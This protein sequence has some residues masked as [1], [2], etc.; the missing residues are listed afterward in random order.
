MKKTLLYICFILI[1]NYAFAVEVFILQKPA[2]KGSFLKINALKQ[3]NTKGQQITF[4]AA[5]GTD[6]FGWEVKAATNSTQYLLVVHDGYG[7]NDY[8]KQECQN[9]ANSLP[10]I[11][12]LAVDL[13]DQKTA[14]SVAEANSLVTSTS[15]ERTKNIIN[16]AIQ[17]AGN[18]S[19][20]ALLGWRFGGTWC[21]KTAIS[22]DEK[23][24]AV[25]MYYALPEIS[26]SDISNL[27]PPI[28][29]IYANNDVVVN[30]K[31][32]AE[33]YDNMAQAGKK[34]I[35]KQYDA[36]YQ[37]ANPNSLTYNKDA[38]ADAY[39]EIIAFLK[40]KFK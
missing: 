6:A 25:V 36:D 24:L 20:I 33:F 39:A 28:M 3:L 23:I 15:Q 37:F 29:A 22:T 31:I 11:N 27:I 10:D 26:K 38:A 7:L 19:K 21:L 14:A 13:F 2:F 32:A 5:D 40:L 16:G 34:L 4:K 35:I 12:I 8:V 9:L 18:D 1:A 30:P 17:Y